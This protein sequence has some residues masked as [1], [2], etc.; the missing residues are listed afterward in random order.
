MNNSVEITSDV[1]AYIYNAGENPHSEANKYYNGYK[2]N[3][4][5]YDNIAD[6]WYA[7]AGIINN[8]TRKNA[9]TITISVRLIRL[10]GGKVA[11]E[12]LIEIDK[13]GIFISNN[14]GLD[15]V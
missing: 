9:T 4:N 6:G 1:T 8:W 2:S 13:V 15:G 11:Q 3:Q 10:N 14:G 7:E 5:K 12:E